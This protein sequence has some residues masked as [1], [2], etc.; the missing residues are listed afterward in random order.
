MVSMNAKLALDWSDLGLLHDVARAGSLLAAA[1]ARGLS[2]S[3]LSRRMAALE[4][5][6]GRRL[7]ERGARGVVMTPAGRELSEVARSFEERLSGLVRALPASS[8]Q[9]EG[10]IRVSVG[11][12]FAPWVSEVVA[13]FRRAHPRVRFELALE[14]RVVDVARRE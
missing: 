4:E 14:E 1:R 11:D 3:T 10:T 9:L 12:G 7:F 13:R 5:T 2:V 8:E 6:L